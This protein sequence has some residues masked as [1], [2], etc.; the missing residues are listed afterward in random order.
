MSVIPSLVRLGGPVSRFLLSS[1][2]RF[3]VGSP[4]LTVIP[5]RFM[6]ERCPSLGLYPRV[7]R[8][9]DIPDIID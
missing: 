7:K 1:Q 4:F 8:V 5:V 6:S 2:T 9:L 3:T